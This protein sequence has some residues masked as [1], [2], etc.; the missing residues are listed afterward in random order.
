LTA[1]AAANTA[2]TRFRPRTFGP[3]ELRHEIGRGGMGSVYRAVRIDGQGPPVA[4]KV[5]YAEMADYFGCMRREIHALSRLRHPGVVRIL[6]EGAEKGVPWYAMELLDSS[7]LD[8]LLSMSASREI[9]TADVRPFEPRSGILVIPDS[10]RARP[11]VRGDLTRALTLMYR[12]ARVLAYVH[13]H[14]IV[15]RDLKPQNVLVREG[16]R[17]VLVDFGLMGQFQAQTGRETLEVGGLMMG[18]ALYAAPEQVNGE[19][20]DARADL[21]SFGAM[22]YEIVAGAPP[23]NAPSVRDVLMQHLSDPPVPIS[24]IVQGVPDVLERLIMRLLEKRR[25]DRLGYAED[26]AAMLVEAGAEPD[27]DFEIE[28]AAY[29]YRPEVIGRAKTIDSLRVRLTGANHSKGAFLCLGGESGIGK[30][31]VA[32]ALAREATINGFRVV[33]AIC[34]AIGAQPLHAFRPLLREIADHCRSGGEETLDRV[35]GPRLQVLRDH[36]PALAALADDAPIRMPSEIVNRRLFADLADTVA[37]FARERPLLLILDDL[38]WADESTLRFLASLGSDFFDD[39]PLMILGT[40]RVDEVGP[41]LRALFDQPYVAHAMLDRLD[42]GSVTDIVR[43]TLA[44]PDAPE[45]FLSFLARH[46]EGNPFFVAEYLRAAVAENLLYR[47]GGR[48]HVRGAAR[49]YA[50]LGLPNTLRDLV[51]RRL[52]GLTPLAQR[53]A[54]AAAV[55]GRD[56]NEQRLLATCGESEAALVEAMT[57]LVERYVFVDVEGTARFAHDKIREGVYA[58]IDGQRCKEL[59]GRAADVIES[60]CASDEQLRL[61][62]AEIAHHCDA[63]GR[64]PQA[65]H[66]YSLGAEA[67]L[68]T[69]ACREAIDLVTR[70]MALYAH[71][72]AKET[73]KERG[74]RHAR[75]HRVLCAAHLGLGDLVTSAEHA[76]TS[77]GAVGIRLPRSNAGWKTRL[78]FEAARQAMHLALPRVTGAR[79]ARRD[80][81]LEVALSAEKFSERSYFVADQTPMLASALIAVNAAERIGHAPGLV[82]SY[83]NLGLVASGVGLHRLADRYFE[84]GR[85]LGMEAKHYQGL[86]HLG[87]ASVAHYITT[88][89][90]KRCEQYAAEAVEIAR[91]AGDHQITEICQTVRGHWEFY[92]GRMQK[93][94][95][96]GDELRDGARKRS[97]LQHECWGYVTRGRSLVPMG[98]LEEALDCAHKAWA[99]VEQHNDHLSQLIS[100]A[101]RTSALLHLDDL[102]A[103]AEAADATYSIALKPAFRMW[104]LFRGFAHPAEVYLEV[105]SRV[106]NDDP[107]EVE[108]MR[109]AVTVLLKHLREMARRAPIVV[110]VTLRLAGVT[111]CLEGNIRRGEKLLRKSATEAKRLGLPLDEGIAE[112]ELVRRTVLDPGERSERRAHARAIFRSIGCELYLRKMQD[113]PHRSGQRVVEGV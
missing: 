70:A 39:L 52:Q 91:M 71:N 58:R 86:A 72:P 103:A 8:E 45:S 38:Q 100:S 93:A 2:T 56:I 47:E 95:E 88:C 3:Y 90:W 21:Y 66:F 34:D 10:L 32:S 104:E 16:D 89:D 73:V 55:L 60:L 46:A 87:Y 49:S 43:S 12:L 63:A 81:L 29:L 84:E 105:W 106:R 80:V 9:P 85:R 27:P 74:L 13:A 35:L 37:A 77:L 108:R 97:N 19:L 68:K 78:L 28:A 30:T 42:D 14:G 82:H 79:E 76:R 50:T 57:E 65:I 15:H 24:A 83:S 110:P 1:N 18:T 20:V 44:A 4:L 112:Y 96:T 111:A 23:F 51:E 98:R 102:H 33:T 31:S 11:L 109:R 6:D 59:H 94:A 62:A 75:W 101:L 5:P 48:W 99:L 25:A 41:D 36:E 26:A 92:T 40:Y 7:S 107:L 64:D 54:E 67:A 17:P 69:G 22:L 53:V 113:D 61:Y